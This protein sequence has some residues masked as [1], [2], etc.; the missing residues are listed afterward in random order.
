MREKLSHFT[1]SELINFNA[2]FEN[3]EKISQ[4]CKHLLK[5]LEIFLENQHPSQIH[6]SQYFL[7]S[8]NV[9]TKFLKLTYSQYLFASIP[10][11]NDENPSKDLPA[12]KKKQNKKKKEALNIVYYILIWMLEIY[13]KIFWKYL[14]YSEEN[15]E[16]FVFIQKIFKNFVKIRKKK[17]K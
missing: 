8:E 4:K 15:Q 6:G 9:L 1:Y 10:C 11:K 14:K 2:I 17:Q 5:L 12:K 16:K 7:Q 3:F 13:L